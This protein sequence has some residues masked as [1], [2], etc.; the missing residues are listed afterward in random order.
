MLFVYCYSAC[1]HPKLVFIS[2]SLSFLLLLKLRFLITSLLFCYLL[3]LVTGFYYD[4]L[5]Q[6]KCQKKPAALAFILKMPK[7]MAMT[8]LVSHGNFIYTI[9]FFFTSNASNIIERWNRAKRDLLVQIG[10]MF[11]WIFLSKYAF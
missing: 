2:I 1:Y 4:A 6:K 11:F 9:S 10:V 3:L 7:R 8:E 5:R